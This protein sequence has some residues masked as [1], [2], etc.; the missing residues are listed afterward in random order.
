MKTKKL[1]LICLGLYV[2][3][4]AR[5][6]GNPYDLALIPDSIKKN[7]VIITH[8]KEEIL[9]I[10]N[11]EKVIIEEHSIFTVLNDEGYRHLIFRE[12]TNPIINLDDAEIKVL[13]KKGKQ[14]AKYRKK[15]MSTSAAG[16][17]LVD[18]LYV[19]YYRIPV[20][21]YP[22]TIE[23][24][25]SRKIK[26]TLTLPGYHL[27][28]SREGLISSNFT[29]KIKNGLTLRY[30]PYFTNLQPT[31]TTEGDYNVY[32]WTASNLT[33]IENEPGSGYGNYPNVD[34]LVLNFS[35]YGV[36]GNF[37]SWN[38]FSLWIINLYKGLDELSADRQRFYQ[39]LVKDAPNEKEKIRLIYQY[40]QK[41]FRY[42]SIQLGIGGLRPFPASFT[43]QKKYG[44]CKGL[45]NYMKAALKTIGIRSH[46]AIINAGHDSEPVDPNFP[47]NHFNHAILCVP[48]NNDTTW[49]EC[50]SPTNAF[51]E[52]GTNTE[53]RNALLITDNGG[54]LVSTPVSRYTTN[55]L[56]T[57]TTVNM[58]SDFSSLVEIKVTTEGQYLEDIKA[59]FKE[60][61]EYQKKY[62]MYELGYRQPDSYAIWSGTDSAGFNALIRLSIKKTPEFISGDK[63]FISTRLNKIWP[64]KLPSAENRKQD[65]YFYYPFVVTDTTILKLPSGAKPEQLP[66][67]KNLNGNY[68]S[69]D[70]NCWY[71]EGQQAII[72]TTKFILKQHRIPA[73]DYA[74]VKKFIDTLNQE[75]AQ[76]IVVKKG[77]STEKK[78]F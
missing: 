76:K 72:T 36:P 46:V 58:E 74:G 25:V 24:K 34:L 54:K 33:P 35:H 64:A 44:D 10:E 11:P 1:L 59:M 29:V 12:Y 15:E 23:T 55:Q 68:T 30:K 66:S 67:K 19:T 45:S 28:G 65:F 32:K 69:Y 78:A 5:S 17:E 60:N 62:I 2:G 41:N 13:D 42:V 22:V 7:A 9:T 6:Q 38:D 52:L 21:E 20:T 48:G 14:I 27:I 50:T 63:L 71:D 56:S 53:N 8:L 75:D 77:E 26:S 47:S 57:T 73:K 3:I 39:N 18:D 16:G 51:G 4:T 37:S 43:D 49:L 40:L 31:T 70:F 61:S